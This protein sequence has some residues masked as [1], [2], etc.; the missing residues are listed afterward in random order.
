M[1]ARKDGIAMILQNSYIKPAFNVWDRH[2]RTAVLTVVDVR[3]LKKGFHPP[4]S[5]ELLH[6]E[7]EYDGSNILKSNV[8][9]R[10]PTCI[11]KY[12]TTYVK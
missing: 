5:H 4:D 6:C 12:L 3:P 9:L 1:F 8:T 7:L 11:S 10:D 2:F